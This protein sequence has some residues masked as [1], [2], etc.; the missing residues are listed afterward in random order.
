[1]L[2]C[3]PP[4]YVLLQKY[5]KLTRTAF[6]LT[7]EVWKNIRPRLE[8]ILE[9]RRINRL[10]AE[11]LNEREERI[12]VLKQLICA[13]ANTDLTCIKNLP[14]LRQIMAGV[15]ALERQ[16]DGDARGAQSV[17]NL[18]Q[19]LPSTEAQL[20]LVPA[21]A[22]RINDDSAR[23]SDELT[24]SEIDE[25]V[26]GVRMYMAKW[27]MA[28]VRFLNEARTY[29]GSETAFNASELVTSGD[30]FLLDYYAGHGD[31]KNDTGTGD[32]TSKQPSEGEDSDCSEIISFSDLNNQAIL[33]EP[34]SIFVLSKHQL[35]KTS[36]PPVFSTSTSYSCSGESAER[37]TL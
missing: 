35:T 17:V 27:R 12:N 15:P 26:Q 4:S 37:S 6:P 32:A 16:I 33:D 11:R 25:I 29:D 24:S 1:M 34:S 3:S 31:D 22:R 14:I 21:L 2:L 9:E 18:Q 30:E 20:L 28:L 19:A 8:S 5:L 13:D 36:Y 10:E 23:A 7:L